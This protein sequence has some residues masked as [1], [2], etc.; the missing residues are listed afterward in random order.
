M[1]KPETSLTVALAT[2]AVVWGVYNSHMPMVADTRAAAPGNAAVEG[3]RKT[4]TWTAA[5]IVGAISLI[6]K[7][8]NIFILGGAMVVVLDW[9]HRHA[10]AVTPGTNKVMVP[11]TASSSYATG[12]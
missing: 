9:T 1:L 12:G 4:A 10:N 6:A 8:P 7:D 2:A 3:T 5:G 11:P